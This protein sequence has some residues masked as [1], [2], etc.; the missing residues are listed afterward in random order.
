MKFH[1]KTHSYTE[2]SWRTSLL[3]HTAKAPFP[4]KMATLIS[5][6][7]MTSMSSHALRDMA[8]MFETSESFIGCIWSGLTLAVVLNNAVNPPLIGRRQFDKHVRRALR[9]VRCCGGCHGNLCPAA[10]HVSAH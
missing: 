9:P 7:R 1:T 10:S 5:V 6:D 2:N 4:Y 8:V 3:H